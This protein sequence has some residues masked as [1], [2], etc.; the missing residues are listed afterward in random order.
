MVHRRPT[1]TTVVLLAVAALGLSG[2][3]APTGGGGGGGNAVES[4]LQQIV[5]GVVLLAAILLSSVQDRLRAST[6]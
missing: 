3:L 2:C 4:S 6:N 5:F 1:W